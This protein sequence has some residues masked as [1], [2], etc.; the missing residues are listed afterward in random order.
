MQQNV[1]AVICEYDP[2]HNGHRY[3]LETARER[4]G[5]DYIVCI[6]SGNIMQRGS[7][8]RYDKFLRARSALCAG[9]DLVLELPVRFSCAPAQ[10]FAAGGLAIAGSLSVCTHLAFGC[11]PELLP[12]LDRLAETVRNETDDFKKHLREKLSSGLAYPSAYAA[13]L[14][15]TMQYP[16]LQ[17]L[18]AAPNAILALQYLR[19]IPDTIQ[20]VAIS[21]IGAYHDNG[22]SA[23]SSASALRNTAQAGKLA[24]AAYAMPDPEPY[25]EAER[26]RDV[27]EPDA[28]SQVLLYLLRTGNAD[29]L[30]N[31]SGMGEGI[32][33]RF[34]DCAYH[35]PDRESLI[36]SVKNRRFPYTRLSRICSCILL[37]LTRE[38]ASRLSVPEY[39]RVLGF[40][41]TAAPLLR[42]IKD[43]CTSIPLI[44][45]ARDLPSA[46]L[47]YQL[48]HR[49]QILWSLGCSNPD[50]RQGNRDLSS[51]TVVI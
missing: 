21:R 32:H 17:K 1:C 25:L 46:S 5:A 50:L 41:R 45:R 47:Q 28:L 29:E 44:A 19:A 49:A 31:I 16:E 42:Q 27:H 38:M 51:P 9:A 37:G 6:M 20:P 18:T 13:A 2:F 34:I 10:D 43:N 39:V 35:V 30:S 26:I 7:F 23:Y 33:N 3:L 11:E 8:A 12:L 14:S 15:K 22:I 36:Q 24:D 48:D 4:T 40:R